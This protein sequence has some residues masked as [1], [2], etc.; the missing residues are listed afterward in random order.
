MVQET[1]SLNIQYQILTMP[2]QT[3]MADMANGLIGLTGCGAEA[4]KVMRAFKLF[5]GV[6]HLFNIKGC[7]DMGDLFMQQCRA[8]RVIIDHIAVAARLRLKTGMEAVIHFFD[9]L[10][11]DV[12]RE[13]AI[14]AHQPATFR[15]HGI[16]IKMCHHIGRMYPGIRAAGTMQVD[17]LIG[18]FAQDFFNGFLYACNSRLLSLPSSIMHPTKLNSHRK[19]LHNDLKTLLIVPMTM[20]LL[21]SVVL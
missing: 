8:H 3:A 17:R 5:R 2:D 16:R 18:D 13:L 20:P 10:D 12:F 15:T 4:F 11:R 14:A 6:Y 1:I 7:I 21:Y 19:T 9:P